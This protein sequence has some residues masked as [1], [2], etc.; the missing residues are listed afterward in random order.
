M[1]SRESFLPI[2][3][4][5]WSSIFYAAQQEQLG[6]KV[7]KKTIGVLGHTEQALK[8]TVAVAGKVAVGTVSLAV[9][10]PRLTLLVLTVTPMIVPRCRSYVSSM[11]TFFMGK[12]G[13]W[14][15]QTVGEW[16]LEPFSNKLTSTEAA[17]NEQRKV[18]HDCNAQLLRL[19]GRVGHIHSD[20]Q[21][22]LRRQGSLDE[23]VRQM[24]AVMAEQTER[25]N[26]TYTVA[27]GVEV[28]LQDQAG[29]LASISAQEDTTSLEIQKISVSLDELYGQ[30]AQLDGRVA[31]GRTESI[32]KLALL[33]RHLG[34]LSAEQKSMF[35]QYGAQF[36]LRFD[37][38]S[39]SLRVL[40]ASVGN[41]Q[42]VVVS[43]STK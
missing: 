22:L 8:A 14:V 33:E 11:G 31:D 13:M 37:Q 34:E 30:L 25:L 2:M 21:D 20:T 42:G 39:E 4:I 6:K 3:V 9:N 10:Y 27:K 40:L 24:N 7:V 17:L 35:Q 15:R 41:R 26:A 19:D 5:A 1:I 23:Q 16:L 12:I 29:R 28:T 32:D 43:N 36:T 38:L 18:I